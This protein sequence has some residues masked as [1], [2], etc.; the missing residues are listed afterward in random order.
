M[1]SKG[2]KKSCTCC[3]KNNIDTDDIFIVWG[4]LTDAPYFCTCY[5]CLGKAM[6]ICISKTR[7]HS[8]K[9]LIAGVKK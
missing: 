5:E 3:G 8:K 2:H 9:P 7:D 1:Q 6:Q 4:S